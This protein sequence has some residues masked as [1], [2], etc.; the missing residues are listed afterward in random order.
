MPRQ[1]APVARIPLAGSELT[2]LT[3]GFTTEVP[4]SRIPLAGP[5]SGL[6]PLLLV[7][8]SSAGCVSQRL[9]GVLELL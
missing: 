8:Q 3:A 7:R 1:L 6:L 2:G 9:G 4:L 5:L